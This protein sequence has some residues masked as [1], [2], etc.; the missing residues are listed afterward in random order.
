MN[1][2]QHTVMIDVIQENYLKLRGITQGNIGGVIK[3]NG[4]GHGLTAVAQGLEEVG[5]KLFFVGTV[6]EGLSLRLEGIAGN[7]F[8]L[9]GIRN[10]KE[11][12]QCKQYSLTPVIHMKEQ[13]ALIADYKE[14]IAIKCDTGMSRLGFQLSE[15]E[16]VLSI[17]KAHGIEI[18]YVFSHLTTS[19]DE[20]S[21]KRQQEEFEAI[22]HRVRVV[23]PNVQLSLGNSGS[24]QC[25]ISLG[26]DIV[27]C[28]IALYGYDAGYIGVQPAMEI[29]THILQIREIP[30]GRT[31]SY[32]NTYTTP[33][34][35]RIASIA[36]GY[37]DGYHRRCTQGYVL[38]EGKK[39]P[40]IGAICMQSFIVDISHIEGI[41]LESR[42]YLLQPSL[43][44]CANTVAQSWGTIS[45]E[46]LCS[47]GK[48]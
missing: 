29:Y 35:M 30:Q 45:Y 10:S 1:Y 44:L 15:I 36:C 21:V 14:P 37:A 4:Y 8:P 13:L 26:Y 33:H 3:A 40:I 16:D 12:E 5:C 20:Q 32:N 31:V 23:Y 43:G 24:L 22:S 7:I 2:I 25:D 18:G 38:I 46:V 34:T 17:C 6:E 19:T 41:T 11:V 39:A 47:L 42:V 48:R 28:G 9:L 27:R